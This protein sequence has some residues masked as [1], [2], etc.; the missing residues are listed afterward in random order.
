MVFEAKLSEERSH[1]TECRQFFFLFFQFKIE[2]RQ[3]NKSEK[4]I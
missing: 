2:K 1:H 4:T 3:E